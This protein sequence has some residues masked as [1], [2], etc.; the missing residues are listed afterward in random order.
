MMQQLAALALR[1]AN[2]LWSLKVTPYFLCLFRSPTRWSACQRCRAW[3]CDMTQ[4]RCAYA[5][6]RFCP[7]C[8][9]VLRPAAAADQLQVWRRGSQ[10]RF[11]APG[12]VSARQDR[13]VLT[14]GRQRRRPSLS[15][16]QITGP[17]PP[18]TPSTRRLLPPGLRRLVL[19]NPP[20]R[21]ESAAQLAAGLPHL[22]ACRLSRG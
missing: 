21:L 2:R 10:Q 13:S 4:P 12:A 5:A 17:L 3:S 6:W 20:L 16:L 1:P 9:A 15:G 14:A 18:V 7:R 19:E 22:Q 11:Q 8:S